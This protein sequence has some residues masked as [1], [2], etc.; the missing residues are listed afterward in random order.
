MQQGIGSLPVGDEAVKGSDL[1]FLMNIRPSALRAQQ[2]MGAFPMPS[3]AVVR[4]DQPFDSFGEITL[5]GD[6]A[7]FDPKR[8]KANVVF[9]ADAYTVRAPR[10]F[11]IAQKDAGLQFK[12]RFEPVAKE[13]QEGRVSDLTYELGNMELKKTC[14]SAGFC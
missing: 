13:F 14:Y 8:L 9:N 12:N 4:Q 2:D 5:V 10:P 1:Q 3:L 7:S 6:P 11:R